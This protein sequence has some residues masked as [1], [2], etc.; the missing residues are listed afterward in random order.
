MHTVYQLKHKRSARSYI[1]V[2]G[3]V[4]HRMAQHRSATF[5]GDRMHLALYQALRQFG[6]DAFTVSV[7]NFSRKRDAIREEARLIKELQPSLNKN[8]K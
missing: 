1:G 2:T 3:D 8:G 7:K 5:K 4:D 6:F